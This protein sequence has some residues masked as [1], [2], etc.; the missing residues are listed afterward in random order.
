MR[1]LPEK[2]RN[3]AQQKKSAKEQREPEQYE[4]IITAINRVADEKHTENDENNPKQRGKRRREIATILS[5]IFGTCV[6]LIAVY[7]SHRDSSDQIVAL[8]GQLEEMKNQRLLTIAQQRANLRREQPLITPIAEGGKDATSGAKVIGWDFSPA[9][10]NI[11]STIA[12]DFRGWFDIRTFND[13]VDTEKYPGVG[14]CPP[15]ENNEQ[16]QEGIIVQPGGG[17]TLV[18][19]FLPVRDAIKAM[20][21]KKYTLMWGHIEYR[22]IFP[23]SPL[24]HEDWCVDV[25]LNDLATNSWSMP[26]HFERID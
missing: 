21:G 2:P 7:I 12:K 26:I 25:I 10:K 24:H 17:K 18:A 5:I 1:K 8:S 3:T 16:W 11:S 22:D 13:D 23:D 20:S 4:K 9:W 14:N 15:F 19:K 6:A